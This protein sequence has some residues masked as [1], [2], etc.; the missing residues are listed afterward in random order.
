MVRFANN[1]SFRFLSLLDNPL[2]I[3]ETFRNYRWKDGL[4]CP[5]IWQRYRYKECG[6]TFYDLANLR[7]ETSGRSNR[8]R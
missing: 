6:K 4:R 7:E 2:E 5:Q 8:D 1:N 3:A